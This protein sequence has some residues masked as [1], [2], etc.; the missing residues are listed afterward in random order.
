VSHLEPDL[1]DRGLLDVV[2]FGEGRPPSTGTNVPDHS[3]DLVEATVLVVS[4]AAAV[5]ASSWSAT[6]VRASSGSVTAVLTSSWSDTA[7]CLGMLGC[8][9]RRPLVGCVDVA[10]A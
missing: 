4:A 2:G 10:I 7:V 3:P 8:P 1:H 9:P 6:A 5:R